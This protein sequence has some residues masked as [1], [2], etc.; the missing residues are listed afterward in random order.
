M[1]NK[2]RALL[3]KRIAEADAILVRLYDDMQDGSLSSSSTEH[4]LGL[5]MYLSSENLVKQSD[6]LN[7]WTKA[8]VGLTIV[9]FLSTVA[10][11][12]LQFV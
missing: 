6:R 2:D 5:L 10:Q 3:K 1:D 4:I 7:C 12:V 11:I 9:L 8:I